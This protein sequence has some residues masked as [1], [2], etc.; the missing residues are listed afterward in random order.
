MFALLMLAVPEAVAQKHQTKNRRSS[1]SSPAEQVPGKPKRERDQVIVQ[2]I[3]DVSPQMA[4]QVD[5]KLVSFG[6]RQTLSV[7]NPG[8]ASSPQGIVAARNWIKSEFE[9]I[10]SECNGCLE[11]KTDT[12]IEQPKG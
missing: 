2:I 7:N 12:F 8:A 9:R 6:T 10:S 5:E 3:K 11:V 4:Q 1:T